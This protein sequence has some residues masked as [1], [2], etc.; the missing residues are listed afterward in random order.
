V[1]GLCA[2]GSI[3]PPGLI[4][5]GRVTP[6]LRPGLY[7][8]AAPRRNPALGDGWLRV[9]F[10]VGQGDLGRSEVDFRFG[11]KGTCGAPATRGGIELAAS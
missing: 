7:S 10:W 11:R 5:A 4:G 1:S 8:G 3:V 9:A 2:G 6:G